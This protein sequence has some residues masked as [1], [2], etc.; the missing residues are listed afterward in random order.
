MEVSPAASVAGSPPPLAPALT[1]TGSTNGQRLNSVTQKE[2]VIP[3]RPKPGR[4]PATDTPPTKRK[5][6]NRAAQRAF[7]ERRA[8]K[9]GELEGSIKV[10][11]Q[12]YERAQES[13]KAQITRLEAEVDEFRGQVLAWQ[14]QCEGL[15]RDVDSERKMREHV[16]GVLETVRRGATAMGTEP[17]A[18]PLRVS[19]SARQQQPGQSL[20]GSVPAMGCGACTVDTRCECID[21]AFDLGPTVASRQKRG[22][23]PDTAT[24]PKRQ[25]NERHHEDALETD[26][27]ALFSSKPASGSMAGPSFGDDITLTPVAADERCGF[28]E[29]GTACVCAELDRTRREESKRLHPLLSQFTPPP[30]DNDVQTRPQA[31]H[32]S[33]THSSISSSSATSGPGTCTQCRA[34]PSSTLFC[35]SLAAMR[36]ATLSSSTPLSGGCCGASTT[37]CC[38][39]QPPAAASASK[40]EG[41]GEGKGEGG[42]GGESRPYLSCADT[43][44]TLSRHPHYAEASDELG[45]WLGRLEPRRSVAGGGSGGASES[46]SGGA[47]RTPMEV[48]AA[49]VMG[50]L[51]LFDRRFGRG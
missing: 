40:G 39:S 50:V 14:Q 46:R 12:E 26:F 35:K 41:E 47:G 1:P 17:V 37:S 36:T 8:A 34:D 33:T 32:Q 25:R 13:L 11:G 51:K 23:S 42:A 2:W 44:T 28:C 21:E 29:D 16:E 43:Y 48:E 15:V 9:V 31:L 20:D 45:S 18:L 4:K 5:A 6:Q 24:A 19:R 27:T 3:P 7:R 49:S 10:V 30:S 22:H 38:K